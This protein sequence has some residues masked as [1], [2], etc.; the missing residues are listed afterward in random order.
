MIVTLL[1]IC[2]ALGTTP[3]TV[4]RSAEQKRARRNRS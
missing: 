1:R 3:A 4:L 2:K